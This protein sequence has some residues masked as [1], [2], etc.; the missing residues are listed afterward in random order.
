[1]VQID[2]DVFIDMLWERVNDFG[3]AG[4]YDNDF[5]DNAF[6]YLKETGWLSD[7]F[8]NKPNYIVDN[9]A[10]NSEIVHKDDAVKEYDEINSQYNGDVEE[11]AYE[12]GYDICGDYIVLDWNL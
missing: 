1:M 10:V 5:W 2:D 9:I 3:P 7:P 4:D 11:W 8:L 12:N 6:D